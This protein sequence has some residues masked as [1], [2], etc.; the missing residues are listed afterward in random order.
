MVGSRISGGRFFADPEDSSGDVLLPR[1][2][3]DSGGV[4][5]SSRR[6]DLRGRALHPV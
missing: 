1:I 2:A 3:V 5:G 4:S 6:A